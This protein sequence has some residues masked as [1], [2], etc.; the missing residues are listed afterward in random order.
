[1]LTFP[2]SSIWDILCIAP[3]AK[4]YQNEQQTS[5]QCSNFSAGFC[6]PNLC[7]L[8][9]SESIYFWAKQNASAAVLTPMKHPVVNQFVVH[10]EFQTGLFLDE[11]DSVVAAKELDWSSITHRCCFIFCLSG[12]HWFK[13]HLIHLYLLVKP[14]VLGGWSLHFIGHWSTSPCWRPRVKRGAA[15]R[16]ACHGCMG[17][18]T[19]NCTR[20]N[21]SPK[22]RDFAGHAHF[23]QC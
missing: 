4:S 3:W 15:T 1:M 14:P 19:E 9:C 22:C 16:R 17:W 2:G 11:I 20:H 18:L 12:F 13:F 7:G 8:S 6:P 21:V 10:H 23:I 5:V